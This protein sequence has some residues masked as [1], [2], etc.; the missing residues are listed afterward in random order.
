MDGLSRPIDLVGLSLG[1]GSDWRA[2]SGVVARGGGEADR[3][4]IADQIMG[5]E[6]D[7]S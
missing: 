2:G 6:G 5:R 1:E 4:D 7:V 3:V